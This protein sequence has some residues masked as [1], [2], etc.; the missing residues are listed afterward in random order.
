MSAG[1]AADGPSPGAEWPG[2]GP[3]HAGR[4]D[5][6]G[7]VVPVDPDP[8]PRTVYGTA[9]AAREADKRPIVPAWARNRDE[10]RQLA[11][12][13][14]RYGAHATGYHLTRTPKYAG[15]LAL[16]VPAGVGV[17]LLGAVGWVFDREAAPLRVAAV[18]RGSVDDYM[19]LTKQRNGR[20]KRRGTVAGAALVALVVAGLVVTWWAPGWAQ[21]LALAAGVVVLGKLGTPG[22][23]R[24]TDPAT[25]NTSAPPRLT[26]EVVTRALQSLGLAAMGPKSGPI[27][28]VAPITR[29]GPG[30]RAD[31]DL[32]HGVTVTDV[33]E[34]RD[35][36]ASG[37]R[38]PL[39]AVWPEPSAEQHAG[40][41]ILWV[42]DQ[43]LN[44][45]KPAAWP[46]AKTGT[47]ELLAGTFPFGTDQRQRAV[48]VSLDQTNML[49]GSLP[50]GGK[51]A[52]VRVLALA[53]ALDVHAELRIFEHKGSGDLA[54][55]EKVA[56]RYVSGVS[57]AA[58]AETVASMREV[59]AELE[60]RA[61]ILG[62]L[63]KEVRPDN[64][65][66]PE[67]AR[68]KGSGLHPLVMV[69]DEA[70]EVFSHAEHGPDAGKLAEAIIKRGRALGVILILATQRPDSK[71]LPTGVSTNVGVR[72]CLRVMDQT[73]NDMVLG[74]SAYKT[75]IRATTFTPRDKGI[76]YLVGVGDEPA[77]VRTYYV[78][79]L[80]AEKVAARA[81]AAREVAGTLSG[82]AL[83]EDVPLTPEASLLDDLRTVFATIERDRVWSE[84]V[85]RAL[86]ELRP[87]LYGTWTAEALTA[88]LK[89]Y[90]ITTGQ[91]WGHTPEGAGAN[92]RGLTRDAVMAAL[93]KHRPN[94]PEITS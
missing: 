41:L 29:D 7:A 92:R 4:G 2:D 78:D 5:G 57:D 81:R 79:A 93:D 48:A 52:A 90:G 27:S 59:H 62:R 20:V 58:I 49:V 54:A 86:T 11:E 19:K 30:W 82:Y 47:V 68:R 60:R 89:P 24:V 40:R 75:G 14:A 23:R 17:A 10:R 16:R 13:L 85:L 32:P 67:L 43:P 88:A 37:L 42:G 28:Y 65:V 12:W 51:T 25:V 71:S 21:A 55:L 63:P 36:L 61:T 33:V 83:G 94:R 77:V 6:A 35:R 74:T 87:A 72:F 38:R 1:A 76:G 44:K 73:A 39:S 66:T 70:Q 80:D 18:A 69:V 15:R 8:A 3:E 64:S 50:G 31:V 53:A 22:D 45:V 34:R 26:A 91:V 84:D 9:L 46:L 56:H